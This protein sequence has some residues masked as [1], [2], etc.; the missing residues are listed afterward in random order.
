MSKRMVGV[1][2]TPPH[3]VVC[4]P[5][6]SQPLISHTPSPPSP[7]QPH[8]VTPPLLI[9]HTPSPSLPSSATL[10]HPSPHQPHSVT[11]S[12][13]QPHSVT[14]SPHQPHS[15]TPSPHQPHS[16]TPSPHQPHSVTPSPHQ[17]HSVTPSPHQPHSV[18]PSP[19]QPHSVTPPLISHTLVTPLPSSATLCHP[20]LSSSATLHHLPSPH[21]PHSITSLPS[22]ATL[23]H[24]PPLISH[25]PS[26]PLPSLL[27]LQVVIPLSAAVDCQAIHSLLCGVCEEE[28]VPAFS[29]LTT[30]SIPSLKQRFTFAFPPASNLYAVLDV[31]KVSTLAN[32]EK[33]IYLFD[34]FQS[35]PLP[36][37]SLHLP[38]P[39]PL[40][41]HPP[42]PPSPYP[43]SPPPPSTP[44]PLSPFPS[45]P[46]HL[47]Q[48]ADT[49]LLVHHAGTGVD[50][51]GQVCLD[52]C[53]SQGLPTTLHVIHVSVD[54]SYDLYR[55]LCQISWEH[56]FLYFWN[57]LTE[58]L[59]YA[60][61]MRHPNMSCPIV[62]VYFLQC[63]HD[64]IWAI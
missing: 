59:K 6:V 38:P 43:P 1:E 54:S 61:D 8:S 51:L 32:Y 19:H 64:Q 12:P 10:R 31:A 23:C 15:V 52:G 49:V 22:S 18:T 62:E 40:P 4:V 53:C 14:P 17:P 56:A 60:C 44:L 57:L 27:H 36:S 5:S 21:Q 58:P 26:P 16:V 2:G 9:S 48:V 24:L 3:L 41:L 29:P 39:I 55:V 11:P 37:R 47:F 45:T 7:H 13:H 35:T 42:P 30:L 33:S 63:T 28:L 25:T 20:S 46:L 34:I 50:S